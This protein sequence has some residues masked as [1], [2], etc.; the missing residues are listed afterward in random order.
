MECI[1][2]FIL[3]KRNFLNSYTSFTC[4]LFQFYLELR[5]GINTDVYPR[6][7]GVDNIIKIMNESNVLIHNL[8][9]NFD[10]TFNDSAQLQIQTNNF[11]SNLS[12][13]YVN[14]YQDKFDNPNPVYPS[15]NGMDFFQ[16]NYIQVYL[17]FNIIRI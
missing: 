10:S 16:P 8:S 12:N 13:F 15:R 3:F 2:I 7:I 11:L 17:N 6:W 5:N 4:S 14:Y 1:F 9:N